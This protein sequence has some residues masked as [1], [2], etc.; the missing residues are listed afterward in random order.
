MFRRIAACVLAS[1][2]GATGAEEVSPARLIE[3]VQAHT[4]QGD[5]SG[6]WNAYLRL[7]NHPQANEVPIKAFSD[8]FSRR[9]CISFGL[10]GATL[11]KSKTQA[12]AIERFCPDWASTIAETAAE[13]PAEAELLK[14]DLAA[15]LRGT[16]EPDCHAWRERELAWLDDEPS[17][18]GPLPTSVP[19]AFW[20]EGDRWYAPFAK[21][22][23]GNAE[24]DF[25]VDIGAG[26]TFLTSTQFANI[27]AAI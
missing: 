20:S 1:L 11:G 14:D 8:C 16:F 17:D 13:H 5:L 27:E 6:A 4:A 24:F 25:L 10:L 7:F 23:M 12:S 21:A 18:D 26:T 19:L 15:I 22:H 3:D 9:G 2:L